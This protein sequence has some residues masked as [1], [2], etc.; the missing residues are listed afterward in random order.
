MLPAV[1]LLCA[2][3]PLQVAF[4]EVSALGMSI[5]RVAE[6]DAT[7]ELEL[8]PDS[9]VV[10]SDDGQILYLHY[11]GPVYDLYRLP[12]G[13]RLRELKS[14]R[15]LDWPGSKRRPEIG[16]G[17]QLKKW[18]VNPP[19]GTRPQQST[20]DA[21][22]WLDPDHGLF[23]GYKT[24]K[25]SDVILAGEINAAE[26]DASQNFAWSLDIPKAT[27]PYLRPS[28]GARSGGG[29]RIIV[30]EPPTGQTIAFNTLHASRSRGMRLVSRRVLSVPGEKS[31]GAMGA[32]AFDDLI[33]LQGKST[34]CVWNGGRESE[35]ITRTR[36]VRPTPAGSI[37]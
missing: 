17:L 10:L 27:I 2:A 7:K 32:N 29:W 36:Q 18:L 31:L 21:M 20:G 28:A 13:R 6:S 33:A 35:P 1:A 24:G 30:S 37:R 8:S 4:D 9:P 14:L 11:G 12:S 25:K 19:P 16:V 15:F 22:A 5:Q 23:V 34:T 3:Q 26:S